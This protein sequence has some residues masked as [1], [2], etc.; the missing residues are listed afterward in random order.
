M[1]QDLT[2]EIASDQK[3]FSL[4][5]RYCKPSC[6]SDEH[7]IPTF[8]RLKFLEKNSN[9]S[10]TWVDWSRGGPHPTR[11]MRTDV[12]VELLERMRSGRTCKYNGKTTN[13]CSLFARKFYPNTLDRLLRFAPKVMRFN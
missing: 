1:D 10:L 9:R 3:Y 12:T 4:F 7:Y 6:Y 5:R 13:V 2:T 11:F 8:L